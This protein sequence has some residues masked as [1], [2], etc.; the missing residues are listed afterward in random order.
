MVTIA[1]AL[2]TF[3]FDNCENLGIPSEE[4][5]HFRELGLNEEDQK[6]MFST[7]LTAEKNKHD[8]VYDW[9][10]NLVFN[11]TPVGVTPQSH[12]TIH[13]AWMALT[14]IMP[15]VFY[16]GH[17]YINNTGTIQSNYNYTL[18]LPPDYFNGEWTRC[19]QQPTNDLGDCRT[20]YIDNEDLSSTD[21]YLNS[22]LLDSGNIVNYTTDTTN[23]NFEC[24]LTIR[25]E[26][27]RKRYKWEQGSCC[28]CRHCCWSY[29][30]GTR[31]GRN[32][33]KCGCGDYNY[34]C[35]Y[36]FND[37]RTDELVLTDSKQAELEPNPDVDVTLLNDYNKKTASVQADDSLLDS[38]ELRLDT[39]KIRK[40]SKSYTYEFSYLPSNILSVLAFDNPSLDTNTYAK[41]QGDTIQFAFNRKNSS[42][43]FIKNTFFN[44]YEQDCVLPVLPETVINISVDEFYY[45]EDE[46]I[47]VTLSLLIDNETS[48]GY[49]NISYANETHYL[50]VDGTA[51]L[52]FAAQPNQFTIYATYDGD[53]TSQSA[54]NTKT[55]YVYGGEKMGVYAAFFW[56]IAFFVGFALI[57][58][59]LYA[60]YWG[61]KD[62]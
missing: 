44:S 5:A 10:T 55:I 59:K 27:E 24:T 50:F 47:N 17:T 19:N 13:N 20:E 15:S 12:L 31:C 21:T 28:S 39:T 43:T 52:D 34:D 30:E 45:K 6:K 40:L 38:F 53:T 29:G 2:D 46:P 57:I 23:N 48:S 49:V 41:L 54:A 3:T 18:T 7:L 56:I 11:Q 37:I 22:E 8:Y 25:N 58:R 42:C 16:D 1:T 26:I 51:E 60:R 4:C 62:D 33:N 9:N 36:K 35:N 32:C 14:A 61:V